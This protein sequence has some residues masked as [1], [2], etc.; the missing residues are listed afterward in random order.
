MVGGKTGTADKLGK[1]GR[2]RRDSRIASFAAAG[3]MQTAAM[4]ALVLSF[5]AELGGLWPKVRDP[6]LPSLMPVVP[7]LG[8]QGAAAAPPCCFAEG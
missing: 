5:P 1:N 2:Y 8:D 7:W 4:V 3:D 6:P